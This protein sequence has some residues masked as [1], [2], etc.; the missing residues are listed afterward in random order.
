MDSIRITRAALNIQIAA[1]VSQ[2][3]TCGRLQVGAVATHEERIIATGYNGPLPKSQPCALQCDTSQPCTNAV[4]AEANLIGHCAK[5]G[6]SLK[7]TNLYSTHQPCIKCAELIV[8]S[9]IVAVFYMH[10]YRLVD[11]LLLLEN[12]QINYFHIDEK[13]ETNNIS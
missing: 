9:G 10:P 1:L 11:G 7:G 8:I 12:N 6:I 4:H 5:N 13:G 2:R 3:G